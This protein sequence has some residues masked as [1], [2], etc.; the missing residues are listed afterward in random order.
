MYVPVSIDRQTLESKGPFA[1]APESVGG[2]MRNVTSV[3]VPMGSYKQGLPGMPSANAVAWARVAIKLR[4][5]RGNVVDGSFA[6]L[7][8]H[9]LLLDANT[10][11]VHMISVDV[12]GPLD[13]LVSDRFGLPSVPIKPVRSRSPRGAEPAPR[14]V[15]GLPGAQQRAADC[16]CLMLWWCSPALLPSPPSSS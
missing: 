10:H 16:C 5:L 4:A 7:V 15:F 11:R 2:E 12:I 14:G 1:F 3:A 13:Q 9:A 8:G 6:H